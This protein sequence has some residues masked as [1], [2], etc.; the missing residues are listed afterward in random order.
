MDLAGTRETTLALDLDHGEICK[1][2]SIDEGNCELVL[3]TI[4][5]EIERAL[6]MD[7]TSG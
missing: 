7:S 2:A 5:S 6:A 3:E 1:F 4:A